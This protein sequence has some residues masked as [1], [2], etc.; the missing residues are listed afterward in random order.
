MFGLFDICCGSGEGKRESTQ[1]FRFLGPFE[2]KKIFVVV[3]G[4]EREST[5]RFRFRGHFEKKQNCK[6]NK[7]LL[8]LWRRQGRAP[9]ASDFGGP[10]NIQISMSINI[11]YEYKYKYTDKW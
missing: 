4:K 6:T 8:W 3:V 10:L 7:Y 1:R 11:V 9:S 2:K 5:Q